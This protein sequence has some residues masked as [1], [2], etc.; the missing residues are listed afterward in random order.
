MGAKKA[1]DTMMIIDG[2][3]DLAWNATELGR[4]ETLELAEIRRREGAIPAHG[5][6]TP[7]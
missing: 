2:H 3:E 5:E 1:M 4:D 7:P 6:G